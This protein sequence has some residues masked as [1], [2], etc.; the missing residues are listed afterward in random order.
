MI[1][2]I[3]YCIIISHALLIL[4][5]FFACTLIPNVSATVTEI[6]PEKTNSTERYLSLFHEH[7]FPFKESLAHVD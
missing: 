6:M 1:F 2:K 4:L 3:Q 7:K 5:C